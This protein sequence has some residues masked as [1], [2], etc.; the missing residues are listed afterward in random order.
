M[1]YINW[2]LAGNGGGALSAFGQGMQ[3]GNYIQGRQEQRA[4]RGALSAYA[5]DPNEENFTNLARTTPEYAIQERGRMEA[6]QSEQAEGQLVQQAM[7]GD[8]NAL[9]QLATVNFDKWK[10]LDAKQRGAIEQETT[11][12][13]NAA[14]DVLGQ[15]PER[16]R[17]AVAAYA[18]RFGGEELD[19]IAQLPDDQ[20]EA[21]LRAAVA[22][23]KM[24][25][26]LV[27]MERPDYQAVP[28]ESTLVNVRDPRAVSQFAG[29]GQQS[30]PVTKQVGQATYFQNPETGQWFDN[31]DEAMGGGVSNGTG[32][33]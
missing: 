12:Y 32:G 8:E 21:A 17:A 4:A 16:R 7:S 2:N 19:Q 27:A 33:F 6:R 29:G 25:E 26:K 20:L 1:S 24:T 30:G 18:Q 13:A 9:T 5:I 10:A 11:M 14:L 22:E 3:L 31:A 28:Y 23:G 15:P